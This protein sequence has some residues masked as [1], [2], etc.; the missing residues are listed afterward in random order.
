MIA[1]DYRDY[2][3]DGEPRVVHIDQKADYRITVP[4]PDVVSLVQA[5]R[6][7]SDYDDDRARRKE[8]DEMT[9]GLVTCS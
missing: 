7:D 3:P 1:F 4:A 8:L 6:P 2:G 9:L 5:L